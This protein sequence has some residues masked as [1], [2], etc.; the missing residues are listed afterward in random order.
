MVWVFT[1]IVSKV[2]GSTMRRAALAPARILQPR[3]ISLYSRIL[4]AQGVTLVADHTLKI[5]A[6]GALASEIAKAQLDWTFQNFDWPWTM[7]D[8]SN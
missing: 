5:L 7:P 1:G 8:D 4:L 2:S 3:P 6:I